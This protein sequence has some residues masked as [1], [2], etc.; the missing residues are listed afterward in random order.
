[1]DG[2][3]RPVEGRYAAVLFVGVV[4]VTT[5][6]SVVGVTFVSWAVRMY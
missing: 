6:L 4:L 3:W 1:M 5:A 2:V